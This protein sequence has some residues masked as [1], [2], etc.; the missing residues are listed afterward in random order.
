MAM[1]SRLPSGGAFSMLD[2]RLAGQFPLFKERDV[3]LEF[4]C[5]R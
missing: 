3:V 5:W 1:E 4:W 2:A